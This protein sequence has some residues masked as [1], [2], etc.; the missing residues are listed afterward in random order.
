MG[1][2]QAFHI[3]AAFPSPP[4][5]DAFRK[6][7]DPSWIDEALSATGTATVRRRRLPP[8][9]V[10][11]VVLGMGMFRDRPIEDVVSNAAENPTV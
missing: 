1:F 7:I 8:D 11:W 9:Q 6:Q 4:T 3:A 10:I 2:Q 5:L